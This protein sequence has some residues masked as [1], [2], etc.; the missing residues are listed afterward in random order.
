MLQTYDNIKAKQL[1]LEQHLGLKRPG[2]G[3]QC[4]SV[5]DEKAWWEAALTR[6]WHDDLEATMKYQIH[7]SARSKRKAK[8]KK[9]RREIRKFID[10][11]PNVSADYTTTRAA[12]AAQ[13]I[14]DSQRASGST[15][16]SVLRSANVTS[17]Q[18][19]IRRR[20]GHDLRSAAGGPRS[21]STVQSAEQ[22][23]TEWSLAGATIQSILGNSDISNNEK[24]AQI[25]FALRIKA[26]TRRSEC[27]PDVP[28]SRW[29]GMSTVSACA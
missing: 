13:A 21:Q 6:A 2:Y 19:P 17:T 20:L 1:K 10:R 23:Q 4:G 3:T 29:A 15:S 25:L 14:T 5:N 22:D 16:P 28:Q 26:S 12:T 18:T 27:N 7:D 11:C 8:M 9:H 24:T